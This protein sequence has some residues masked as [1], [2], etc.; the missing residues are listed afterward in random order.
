NAL[1]DPVADPIRSGLLL[2]RLAEHGQYVLPFEERRAAYLA[3]V[4]L[5]PPEPASGARAWVLAGLGRFMLQGSGDS[6][7]AFERCREA[8]VPAEAA[9][10]RVVVARALVPLGS[11]QV[12]AGQVEEGL[13]SLERAY[14]V[15]TALGDSYERAGCL[16]WR[17]SALQV[18]GRLEES[19]TVAI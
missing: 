12:L 16:V 2:E 13:A 8:L 3:A 10:A 9:G 15:A 1:V 14:A 6:N 4:S 17:A 11:A 18:A 5:V 19:V 7:A